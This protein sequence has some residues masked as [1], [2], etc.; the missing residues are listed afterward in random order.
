MTSNP[1]TDSAPVAASRPLRVL[2]QGDSIT[3]A[4]RKPAEINPA[5]QLGTG[6]VFLIASELALQHPGDYEL[7]NRGVS[8]NGVD[9]LQKRWP[10]DTLSLAP[11][12]LTILIGVNDAI[13]RVQRNRNLTTEQFT[14]IYQ[15]L[16][17][18][19]RGVRPG[20]EIVLME[21][22]L[23]AAGDV[24]DRW[25]QEIREIQGAVRRIARANN[26]ALIGLQN[27]FNRAVERAPAGFWAYDGFHPTHAGFR[28]IADAWLAHLRAR[29]NG[30][31]IVARGSL[32]AK[33]EF[34]ACKV[35]RSH[36]APLP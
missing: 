29:A 28:L 10:E 5:F 30:H 2:F 19:A 21:P 1:S 22:F 27:V 14:E 8:G 34:S 31:V 11:D 6:Y 32:P 23:V 35:R 9:D 33:S 12:V 3:D 25:W 4:F 20:L 36:R 15:S 7:L 24:D 16:I 17:D 26:L 18:S 13:R